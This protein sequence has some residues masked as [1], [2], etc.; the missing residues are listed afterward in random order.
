MTDRT[1]LPW[2]PDL[3]AEDGFKVR[4]RGNVRLLPRIRHVGQEEEIPSQPL[5]ELGAG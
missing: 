2:S 4:I 3:D 5:F 1:H